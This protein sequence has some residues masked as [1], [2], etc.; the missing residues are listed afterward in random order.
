MTLEDIEYIYNHEVLKPLVTVPPIGQ[1]F[2]VVIDDRGNIIGG[3][4]EYTDNDR[5][6]IQKIVVDDVPQSQI[7]KES[8]IRSVIYILERKG[9]KTIFI[10]KCEE[11]LCKRIGFRE[12]MEINKDSLLFI[13]TAKFF[14]KT[15]CS[16]SIE[17]N[18]TKKI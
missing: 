1:K 18:K 8:L 7:L 14:Q 2:G 3:A 10:D 5:A 11:E 17:I 13:D 15:C 12:S 4:T 16:S 6:V 9:I